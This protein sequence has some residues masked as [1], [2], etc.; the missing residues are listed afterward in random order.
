MARESI[1]PEWA[2]RAFEHHFLAGK[3]REVSGLDPAGILW[4]AGF[5]VL[6]LSGVLWVLR[7]RVRTMLRAIRTMSAAPLYDEAQRAGFTSG[8]GTWAYG[9]RLLVCLLWFAATSYLNALAA[10]TAG[11][12]TPNIV[13]LDL[14]GA[15]TSAKTLPDVG[16]DLFAR[17]V[18]WWSGQPGV[19][20]DYMAYF[21]VPDKFIAIVGS[22]TTLF[23]L[24]HPQRLLILRRMT[25]IFGF[26]NLLRAVCVACTSLPDASPRCISQFGDPARG[27]YKRRPIFPKAYGRA[28]KL[29][30]APSSHISCGDMVFSGHTVLLVMCALIF[31]TYCT[32]RECDT[33]LIRDYLS[34]KFLTA[35]KL[36]IYA[37]VGAGIFSIV[38]TRLHYSLDVLI[39]VFLAWRCWSGYHSRTLMIPF[40]DRVTPRM[41]EGCGFYWAINWLEADSVTKIDTFGYQKAKQRATSVDFESGVDQVADDLGAYSLASSYSSPRHRSSSEP[42]KLVPTFALDRSTPRGA[43]SPRGKRR[44]GSVI[45]SE[46]VKTG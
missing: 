26:I 32:R 10:V 17:L 37:L 29:L 22:L 4:M 40:R 27:A 14:D 6:V 7:W 8:M 38:G 9:S 5:V 46:K 23:M 41:Y 18:V 25:A 30:T 45:A 2:N 42:I 31:D 34:A 44:S 21:D 33:P 16:H 20:F 35:M 19:E 36:C 28:W 12:R 43:K 39:A 1:F 24:A 15:P 13:I 11:W 3:M